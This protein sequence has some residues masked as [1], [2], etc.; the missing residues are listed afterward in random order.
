MEQCKISESDYKEREFWGDYM[1]G[2]PG[3]AVH[4]SSWGTFAANITRQERSRRRSRGSLP[5]VF[6]KSIAPDFWRR[7]SAQSGWARLGLVRRAS[8]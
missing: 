2:L 1:T 3:G 8:L 7:L 6:Q 4:R 5:V